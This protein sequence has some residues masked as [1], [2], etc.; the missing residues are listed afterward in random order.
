MGEGSIYR[1]FFFFF[2]NIQR[3]TKWSNT[4]L[5]FPNSEINKNQSISEII[6]NKLCNQILLESKLKTRVKSPNDPAL[7]DS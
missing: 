3:P 1:N 7:F 2:D 6:E 4:V 5:R